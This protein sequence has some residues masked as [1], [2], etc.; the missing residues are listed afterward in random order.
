MLS[1]D[2]TKGYKEMSIPSTLISNDIDSESLVI[3]LPGLGYTTKSPIFHYL[4]DIFIQKSC[5]VLSIDYQYNHEAYNGFSREEIAEAIKYDVRTVIDYRLKDTS[6]KHFYI[7]GKSLG[8]IAM[9]SEL[10]RDL[11]QN[12]KFVWLTPLLQ[13]DDVFQAMLNN[14]NKELHIIGDNDRCYI[15]ERYDL[16]TSKTNS[17]SRLI[18]GANHSLE[19][20]GNAGQSIDLLKNII[21]E[22]DMFLRA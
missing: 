12:A 15:K 1:K 8:S 3:F 6:Y 20:E 11:F 7:I 19:Y 18:P 14:Q 17:V 21:V 4:T 9:S 16:L 2:V 5:D 13:R 22:I 10:K